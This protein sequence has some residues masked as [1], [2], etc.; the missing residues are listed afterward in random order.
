M[1]PCRRATKPLVLIRI[2][3]P[4]PWPCL[5]PVEKILESHSRHFPLLPHTIALPAIG[6]TCLP[7]L[8]R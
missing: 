1:H 5:S 3:P 8:Q 2:Q 4:A 6:W 7:V